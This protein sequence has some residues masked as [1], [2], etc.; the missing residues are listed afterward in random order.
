VIYRKISTN[1]DMMTLQ[2]DVDRLGEWAIHNA[3]KINPSK[4]KALFFTRA[5]VKD[6]LKYSLLGT[7]VPEASSCKY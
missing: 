1:K 3:M 7:L 2:R 5:R 4:S 6:P